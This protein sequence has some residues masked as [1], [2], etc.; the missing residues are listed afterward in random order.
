MM[1][2]QVFHRGLVL[3]VF[4]QNGID[5]L[6]TLEVVEN[7]NVFIRVCEIVGNEVLVDFQTFVDWVVSSAQVGLHEILGGQPPGVGFAFHVVG[8]SLFL[9][10]FCHAVEHKFE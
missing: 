7:Q 4:A 5:E 8:I 10:V 9:I 1:G 3:I 2:L 6:E